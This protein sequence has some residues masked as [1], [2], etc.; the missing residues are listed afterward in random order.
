MQLLW[1]VSVRKVHMQTLW[2]RHTRRGNACEDKN[3]MQVDYYVLHMSRVP[4]I[5]THVHGFIG[6]QVCNYTLEYSG[7]SQPHMCVM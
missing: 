6:M 7:M 4:K 3:N 2:V 5:T 1:Y